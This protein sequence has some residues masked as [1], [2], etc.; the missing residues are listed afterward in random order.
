MIS[1]N[2]CYYKKY[3]RR[4]RAGRCQPG[5]AYHLLTSYRAEVILDRHLPELQR[6]NLLEPVLTIKKLRLGKALSALQLVPDAPA[7]T[8]I[9]KAVTHLQQ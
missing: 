6:S 4:G 7:E 9:K 8:T 5:I 2:N 3:F 1:E